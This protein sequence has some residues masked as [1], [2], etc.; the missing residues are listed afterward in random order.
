[1]KAAFA[2]RASRQ[3]FADS[4]GRGWVVL[5]YDNTPDTFRPDDENDTPPQAH[6]ARCGFACH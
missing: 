6:D 1:V 4:G 5:E 3:K 2:L